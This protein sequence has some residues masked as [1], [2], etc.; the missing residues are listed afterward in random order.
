MSKFFGGFI[1][2]YQRPEI[3]LDTIQKLFDQTFP[4]EKLWI[5]DNSVDS[6]T[7]Q[8]IEALNSNRLIYH[9]VGHNAGPAGAAAIGLRIVAE[10]GYKWVFWGDDD[11]PPPFENS[12]ENIFK[13]LSIDLG[14]LRIGQMGLVGQR[15]DT[16]KGKVIRIS[17]AELKSQQR[18]EV[19]TIAGGQMKIVSSKVVHD[20][21]LPEPDLFYGY[22]E[23]DFDLKLKK[24]GYTSLVST[25]EFLKARN[26][27]GR[28]GFNRPAYSK[29]A[30][31][32]LWR[33]YYSTRNL[34]TVLKRNKFYFGY[35]VCLTK[36]LAKGLYGFRYGWG[37]G[38][39]N[40]KFVYTGIWHSIIKEMGKKFV[41][42][43]E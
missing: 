12:F 22:E 40:F 29:K 41:L 31:N 36:S 35:M 3:L 19:D 30:S 34:L 32:K 9:R 21:V 33:E 27:Y 18:I 20:G 6:D 4:P 25:D 39:I 17:D 28:I 5:I 37:F 15:F 8:K 7:L 23:L 16:K 14:D 38:V 26:K 42:Q 10:A 24:A 11:D 2:T 1:I 43:N 13:L